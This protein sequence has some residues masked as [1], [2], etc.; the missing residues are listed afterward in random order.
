MIKHAF[1]Q[2]RK[3][4]QLI[5]K[6]SGLKKDDLSEAIDNQS[7]GIN[8]ATKTATKFMKMVQTVTKYLPHTDAA[9]RKARGNIEAMCC[10][11]GNPA[12]F[13]TVT[14]DEINGVE[15]QAFSRNDIDINDIEEIKDLSKED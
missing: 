9:A 15:L 4:I 10:H 14:F 5:A 7:H 13:L 12:Y 2:S 1:L 3:H 6:F 8:D 11:F